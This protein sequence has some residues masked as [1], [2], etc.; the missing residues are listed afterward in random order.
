MP[1]CKF[2]VKEYLIV[3]APIESATGSETEK[4]RK[5]VKKALR[6][7]GY[8]GIMMSADYGCT[9]KK[10]ETALTIRQPEDWEYIN[11]FGNVDGREFNVPVRVVSTGTVKVR[12]DSLKEAVRKY[13]TGEV[14]RESPRNIVRE[15]SLMAYIPQGF[16]ADG[17]EKEETEPADNL[18]TLQKKCLELFDYSAEMNES[19][20]TATDLSR[21]VAEYLPDVINALYVLAKER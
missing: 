8:T 18:E 20:D 5:T 2:I 17:S 3:E 9:T 19:V 1:S 13:N 7:A 14:I 16:N 12:A 11:Y 15:E 4:A 6:E 21:K 10:K